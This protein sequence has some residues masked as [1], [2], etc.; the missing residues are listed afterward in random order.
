MTKDQKN[1]RNLLVALEKRGAR[2]ALLPETS[3]FVIL[4]VWLPCRLKRRLRKLESAILAELRDAAATAVQ[5]GL[6][7]AVETRPAPGLTVN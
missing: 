3:Q 7:R 4:G 1:A 2:L 5:A 6:S